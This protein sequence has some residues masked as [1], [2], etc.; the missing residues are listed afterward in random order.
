MHVKETVFAPGVAKIPYVLETRSIKVRDTFYPF[1]AAGGPPQR[2]RRH[3][4]R[5]P[6]VAAGPVRDAGRWEAAAGMGVAPADRC[7][8]HRRK[9]GRGGGAGGDGGGGKW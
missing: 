6:A 2:G 4:A 5:L 1:Q 7:R 8:S 9:A 3:R